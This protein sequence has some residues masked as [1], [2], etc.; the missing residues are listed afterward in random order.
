MKKLSLGVFVLTS[1]FAQDISG[2]WRADLSKSTVMG[3]PDDYVVSISKN[4]SALTIKTL[5]VQSPANTRNEA[6]YDRGAAETKNWIR[7]NPTKSHSKW[8]GDTLRIDSSFEFGGQT[9]SYHEDWTLKSDGTLELVRTQPPAP[10]TKVI[11]EKQPAASAEF[12]KPEKTAKE[13]YQNVTT[14]NV[15]A[16][17]VLPIMNTYCVSLGAVCSHCHVNGKWASDDN[18]VKATARKMIAMTRELNQQQ[19]APKVGVSCYTCHRGST[20]PVLVPAQ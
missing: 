7:G 19:F 12:D 15:P 6:V 11:F 8:D 2:V 10:V 13:A 5:I 20:K 14:L 4:G 17:S 9:N 16:S 3:K 18:P 1:G